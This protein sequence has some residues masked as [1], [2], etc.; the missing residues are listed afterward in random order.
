MH[1]EIKEITSKINQEFDRL[2]A[3]DGASFLGI[4]IGAWMLNCPKESILKETRLMPNPQPTD[5]WL[6]WI[7]LG[8][9]GIRPAIDELELIY[10]L[11]YLVYYTFEDLEARNTE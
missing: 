1:S 10:R 11:D 8:M 7:F 6:E 3:F 4:L 5:S 2:T 9:Q